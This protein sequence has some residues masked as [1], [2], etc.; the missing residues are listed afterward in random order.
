[1]KIYNSN[2]SIVATNSLNK[3]T[4]IPLCYIDTNFSSYSVNFLPSTEFENESKK[5]ITPYDKINGDFI[6]LFDSNENLIDYENIYMDFQREGDGYIYIPKQSTAFTPLRFKYNV[7]GKKFLKYKTNIIYN[8]DAMVVNNKTL[9]NKL[10]T[11]FGDAPSRLQAPS[12]IFVNNGDLDLQSLTR[13]SILSTDIA[14]SLMKNHETIFEDS[15][16][17]NF[18]LEVPFDKQVYLDNRI[19]MFSFYSNDFL[20]DEDDVNLSSKLKVNHIALD[21]PFEFQLKSPYIYKDLF[22]ET[23][24]VFKIPDEYNK[25]NIKYHNIF[26]HEMYSPIL[27]EEHIGKCFYIYASEDLLVNIRANSDILYEIMFWI[28]SKRYLKTEEIEEW[29]SDTIPDYI[30]K[31]NKLEKKEK[32]LSHVE[33][34][35]LFGL[36]SDEISIYSVN[37]DKKYPFVKYVGKSN[38]YIEFKKD[39]EDDNSKYKDPDKPK[40]YISIY[41]QRQNIIYCKELFYKINNS[42][43]KHVSHSIIG[44][45]LRINIEEFKCSDKNIY[46]K[47]GAVVDIALFKYKNNTESQIV[48]ESFYLIAT[49]SLTVS[50]VFAKKVSEYKAEDGHILGTIT[51]EQKKDTNT[52]HDLRKRGGGLPLDKKDNFN[53]FDIGNIN[54]RPYRRAATTIIKLPKRL[55]KH[56]NLIY[57]TIRQYDIAENYCVILFEDI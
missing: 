15:L 51:I 4:D 41:T 21:T 7:I 3:N 35:K 55:E 19:N 18:A 32:F 45:T 23:N 1:M 36:N 52:I 50:M 10:I 42:I 31:N 13:K 16:K 47:D 12:N 49:D 14:F 33:F 28:Y 57:K 26:N 38:N 30:V 54:G 27:I 43:S 46:I 34:H 56:K 17:D 20:I 24:K 8:I 40:G 29:I 25:D 37:I 48:N 22:L 9:A 44:K 53:C 5:Q 11:I 6:C 39:I 2:A